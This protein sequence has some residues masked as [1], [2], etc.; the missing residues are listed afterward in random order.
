MKQLLVSLVLLLASPLLAQQ[1]ASY[2][3]TDYSFNAG[4]RLQLD[5]PTFSVTAQHSIASSNATPG[6]ESPP[7][8]SCATSSLE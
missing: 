5:S 6:C 3:L 7:S 8:T 4:G 1:S 2:R